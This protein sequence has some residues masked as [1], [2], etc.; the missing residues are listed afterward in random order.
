MPYRAECR[1]RR[2]VHAGVWIG[3]VRGGDGPGG[4]RF[5]I[6]SAAFETAAKPATAMVM[7]PIKTATTLRARLTVTLSIS[8]TAPAACVT[9]RPVRDEGVSIAVAGT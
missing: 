2:L 8:V 4:R 7:R 9:D 6:R 1:S 5:V 3:M